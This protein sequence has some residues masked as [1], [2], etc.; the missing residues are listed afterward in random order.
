MAPVSSET[1]IT[2]ASETSLAPMAALCLVPSSSADLVAVRQR[3][4]ACSGSH[5]VAPH[6]RLRRH[7]VV[8]C[9]Q[10]IDEQLTG[11]DGH[12]QESP[13]VQSL[14]EEPFAQSGL[15]TCFHRAIF[16]QPFTISSTVRLCSFIIGFFRTS[17]EG[18]EEFSFA[19]LLQ[20]LSQLRLEYN[21]NRND[22]DGNGVGK[23][24]KNRIQL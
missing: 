3:Q 5:A 17:G 11:N 22:A 18:G 13:C 7:A 4:K 16:R 1:T 6:N 14:Q 24:P 15:S 20:C 10:N 9:V 21:D 2:Y 12:P 23:N 19:Q 8:Y